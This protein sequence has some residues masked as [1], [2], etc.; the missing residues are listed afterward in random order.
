MSEWPLLTVEALAAP[1]K[2]ALATGPFGSSIGSKT[3][4]SAGVPVLRGGNLSADVGIRLNEED[5]VFI[6]NDL[7]KTFDRSAA[8]LGDV[9]FT[10][11]G[12]INQVGIITDDA[13]YKLYIVSNKQMKVT[14][15]RTKI[16]PLYL[17]YYFSSPVGQVEIDN[18]SIGSSVPGFNLTKLRSIEVPT[19]PLGIQRGIVDILAALDDKITLNRR[20]NQTL[21]QLAQ[22]IFTDWF[23]DFGPVRRKRAGATDPVAIMGGLVQDAVRAAELS[24]AFPESFN[25]DDLPT[26][27]EERPFSTQVNIIGGGTPKTSVEGYWNGEIPWFS[28]VDTPAGGDVFVFHTEKKITQKGADESSVRLIGPGTTIISARGTV[29]N[30]AIAGREMAFNQSCYALESL[31][32]DLPYFVY[33]ATQQIVDRLKSM[34]HG[35][36]FSTITRQTFDA[37]AFNSPPKGICRLF[38]TAAKP[39][40]ECIRAGVVENQ[41]LAETRDFLLPKLMSGDVPIADAAKLIG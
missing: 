12:T 40:Y 27:W 15:D 33:L 6:D 34:A 5:L 41:I 3:F 14:P 29:G 26:D 18:N 7:A 13:K 28:V 19:P 1:T 16:H 17:Y 2:S 36:V 32:R 20:K 35:S 24:A 38:E 22:T 21:G 31:E 30:L 4:R 37:I 10:C 9:V 23:I 39:L 8:R 25:D 11:W